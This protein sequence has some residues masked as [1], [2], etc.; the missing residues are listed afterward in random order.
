MGLLRLAAFTSP[1][2]LFTAIELGWRVYLPPLLGQTAGL[3]LAAIGAIMLGARILDAAADPTIGWLSDRYGS[4]MGRRRPW[5]IAGVPMVAIGALSLFILP[6]AGLVPVI[7][8]SILLHLGYSMI[9]TPHGGWALEL[10]ND[11]HERT[12]IMGAKVWVA[13]AGSIGLMLLLALLERNAGLDQRALA[14][15]V[16][17]TILAL[18][19]TTVPI[20][21]LGFRETAPAARL[22][23]AGPF[24]QF[25]EMTRNPATRQVLALYLLS[26]IAD[27]AAASIFLFAAED[28]FGLKG[29]GASLLLVQPVV[30]LIALPFWARISHRLGRTRTLLLSYGWQAAVAPLIFAVPAGQPLGLAAF[31]LLRS[32]S[33]GVDYML[34]RAIVADIAALPGAGGGASSASHYGVTSITL[35]LAMSVGAA[36][37]LWIAAFA[38]FR[39]GHGAVAPEAAIALRATFGLLPGLTSLAATAVLLSGRAPSVQNT[40]TQAPVGRDF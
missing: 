6:V 14:A 1:V 8:A 40:R 20:V 29:W 33:W 4:K 19:F 10:S 31:L 17:A 24:A 36:M 28:A 27:A 22:S 38:G 37:S 13:A 15:I 12:L 16:G 39:P 3:S 26:G 32:L 7:V 25:L 34:L 5:M 2:L 35:K 9:I 18:A 23:A 21:T 11:R 30:A